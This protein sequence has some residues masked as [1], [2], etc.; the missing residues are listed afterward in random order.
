MPDI[1]LTE[2]QLAE[3][4][5]LRE[6]IE[7]AF[8]DTYGH[9]RRR[10][11][12]DYLLDTYTPPGERETSAPY[13]RIEAAGYPELQHIAAETPGVPGSGIDADEMRWR[14]LSELGAEELAARLGENGEVESA[15]DPE[16]DS[17]HDGTSDSESREDAAS[18]DGSRPDEIPEIESETDANGEDRRGDTAE[19]DDVEA[20]SNGGGSSTSPGSGGG[21]GILASANQLLEEHDDKWHKDDSGD[22]PFEVTLPDGTSERVRTRDDV[23]KLLF[24][25]Y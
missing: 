24:Q 14:L 23:R 3:I 11:V 12:V 1:E 25:H 5:A 19:T 17:E 15:P 13:E 20:E 22:E 7:A 10:D 16:G 9:V 2:S 8:V 4:D 18:D 21:G 6:D